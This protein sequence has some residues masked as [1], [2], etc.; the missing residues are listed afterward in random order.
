MEGQRESVWYQN[1][2]TMTKLSLVKRCIKSSHCYS[3]QIFSTE[4][5]L[6][7]PN[8][9]FPFKWWLCVPTNPEEELIDSEHHV[10]MVRT[11]MA[12]INCV[13]GWQ[14]Y[15]NDSG[16]T[17][18]ADCTLFVDSLLALVLIQHVEVLKYSHTED[19]KDDGPSSY[20]LFSVFLAI[21][22]FEPRECLF[23]VSLLLQL[24]ICMHADPGDRLQKKFRKL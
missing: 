13:N 6:Q 11:Y 1:P 7:T 22:T 20:F 3:C 14:M 2:G 23:I 8:W 15:T 19:W 9:N 4:S 16:Q 17:V 18:F 10:D 24:E 21:V 5:T 12:G